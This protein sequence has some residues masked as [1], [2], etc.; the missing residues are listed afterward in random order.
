MRALI[1]LAL[2]AAAFAAELPADPYPNASRIIGGSVTSISQWPEMAALLFSWGTT[3]HR[4]SC[5]GTI[6]NQRSILSAAHCFVG[7]ATDRWQVRLGSTNANSGGVVFTTQQLINH[8][9]YNSPVRYNNDVAIV[10]VAG[11][12]SYGSN[13]R[14]ANIAGANYNPGDN[15][16]V[17]ATGWG[18]TGFGS[19]SEQLRQVQVWTVNQAICTNRYATRNWVV[20]PNML[21]SGW[22]D[23]GGRDQCQG[24]SG[25]PLFHNRNVV[26]IC[27]W[28]IGCADSFLP[29]VNARVF[30]YIGWIQANA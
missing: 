22:L 28:G 8:P 7:H 2:V 17:W 12:I 10:R 18:Y 1:V 29:G 15:Q 21:C 14:A 27:S 16:V 20:T 19:T 23:V 25:G 6:L 11:S 24:D 3:G 4:Q 13:I 5:G 26:G 30:N 9:Q